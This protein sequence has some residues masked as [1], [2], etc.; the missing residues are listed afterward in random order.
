VD[1]DVGGSA[2]WNRIFVLKIFRRRPLKT[3][4]VFALVDV[5]FRFCPTWLGTASDFDV[6]VAV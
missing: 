1:V 2:G 3:L 6:V 4:T 5:D